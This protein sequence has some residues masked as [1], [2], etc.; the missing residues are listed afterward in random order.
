MYSSLWWLGEVIKTLNSTNTNLRVHA[1]F[2]L[3]HIPVGY[4][5]LPWERFVEPL[6]SKVANVHN[7]R[8]EVLS[9]TRALDA[10][11]DD[12]RLRWMHE[13]LRDSPILQ[14]LGTSFVEGWMK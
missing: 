12:K 7:I 13:N 2:L 5:P 3:T 8:I 6:L 1:N 14:K 4:E 10:Y 9:Y 11:L